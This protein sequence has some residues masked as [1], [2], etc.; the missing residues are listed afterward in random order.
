[1][2]VRSSQEGGSSVD[3]DTAFDALE[4]RLRSLRISLGADL[5]AD[6]A[7]DVDARPAP[8]PAAPSTSRHDPAVDVL[9]SGQVVPEAD[10]TETR[11]V[12][13]RRGMGADLVLIAAAW[14][15][16]IVLVVRA[17]GQAS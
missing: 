3:V 1:M 5:G 11:E 6:V 13:A 12:R 16:L 17:L 15:V 4:D 9:T 7:A 8:E 14:S 2:S 10:R